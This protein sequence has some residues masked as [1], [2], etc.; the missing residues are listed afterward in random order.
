MTFLWTAVE[1]DYEILQSQRGKIIFPSEVCCGCTCWKS[2]NLW[3][4]QGIFP[5]H[6]N[7]LWLIRQNKSSLICIYLSVTPTLSTV[8]HRAIT[9][10]SM[11]ACYVVFKVL[12]YY[13]CCSYI[14]YC[15][16]FIYKEK[17]FIG[18][19]FVCFWVCLT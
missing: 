12:N 15:I 10:H 16:Y 3:K 11:S 7:Y 2:S 19:P 17:T 14:S 4:P 8:S 1:S 18:F 5:M 9:C 6:W 13:C